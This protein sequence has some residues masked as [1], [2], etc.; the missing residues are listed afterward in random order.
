MVIIYSLKIFSAFSITLGENEHEEHYYQQK[1]NDDHYKNEPWG[2]DPDEKILR[3]RFF[4]AA[5]YRN[6]FSL[7]TKIHFQA[8][9]GNVFGFIDLDLGNVIT[10]VYRSL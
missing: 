5:H 1:R 6:F 2:C 9:F 4:G 7:D 10:N 3:F 8:R